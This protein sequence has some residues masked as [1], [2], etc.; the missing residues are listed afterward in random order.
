MCEMEAER[1]FVELAGSQVSVRQRSIWMQVSKA[2]STGSQKNAK[3]AREISDKGKM[4]KVINNVVQKQNCFNYTIIMKGVGGSKE[5]YVPRKDWRSQSSA[6][7]VETELRW[8][9]LVFACSC[10]A[11]CSY[12]CP[13]GRLL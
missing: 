7:S 12:A 5:I 11:S 6:P 3:V 4:V 8:T 1:T 10:R 13:N 9:T 2:T